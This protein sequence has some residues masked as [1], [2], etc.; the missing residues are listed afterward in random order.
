MWPKLPQDSTLAAIDL[1]LL[2]QQ[3][4]PRT[5]FVRELDFPHALTI[6]YTLYLSMRLL[7]MPKLLDLAMHLAVGHS[8]KSRQAGSRLL[9]RVGH[10]HQSFW[11]PA[12]L[13]HW[14]AGLQYVLGDLD[15]DATPSAKQ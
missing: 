7:G 11:N 13:Q 3:V 10:W 9:L 14:L 2:I 12:V 5:K 1:L 8:G 15:A 4:P 6:A